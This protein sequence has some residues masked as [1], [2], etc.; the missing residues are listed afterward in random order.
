VDHLDPLLVADR[1]GHFGLVIYDI[2]MPRKSG[3]EVLRALAQM[4]EKV[5]P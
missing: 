1:E 2:R 5:K 3:I 4:V